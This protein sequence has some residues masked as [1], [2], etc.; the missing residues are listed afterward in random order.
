MTELKH[1]NDVIYYYNYRI[2]LSEVNKADKFLTYKHTNWK[3]REDYNKSYTELSTDIIIGSSTIKEIVFNYF[4]FKNYYKYNNKKFIFKIIIFNTKYKPNVYYV[5][6]NNVNNKY[7]IS[8]S[9]YNE[10]PFNY[11]KV[12][13]YD[14]EYQLMYDQI[15]KLGW[16]SFKKLFSKEAINNYSMEYTKRQIIKTNLDTKLR[17]IK[18]RKSKI[19]YD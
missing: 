16:K 14:K 19:L 15:T 12:Y 18:Y 9:L 5:S 7:I 13:L 17:S 6:I 1:I 4:M 10:K 3:D 8:N 2:K 11:N